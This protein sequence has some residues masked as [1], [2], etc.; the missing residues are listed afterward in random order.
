MVLKIIGKISIKLGNSNKISDIRLAA[1]VA[2]NK[3]KVE[4]YKT[5]YTAKFTKHLH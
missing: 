3:F 4:S 1:L 5:S 2:V